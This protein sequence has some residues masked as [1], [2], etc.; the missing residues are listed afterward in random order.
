MKA[1]MVHQFT[2]Y[3]NRAR[4]ITPAVQEDQAFLID[5]FAQ[6]R[7]AWVEDVLVPRWAPAVA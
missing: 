6:A 7:G 4:S 2:L 3:R 5:Y 1:S